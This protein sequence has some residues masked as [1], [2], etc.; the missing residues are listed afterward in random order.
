MVSGFR[1]T[2]HAAV[3]LEVVTHLVPKIGRHH[4]VNVIRDA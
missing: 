1:F 2:N 4:A 3:V